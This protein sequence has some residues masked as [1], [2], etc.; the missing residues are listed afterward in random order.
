MANKVR[1][2]KT[3]RYDPVFLD[4]LDA[5]T[6]LQI[7][8]HVRVIELPGA[9]KANTMQHCHV[10]HLNGAFAG[11]VHTNSL[12]PQEKVVVG[13]SNSTGNKYSF[14]TIAEA[15]AFIATFVTKTD[16]DGV[17]AGNY[18]IDAP[19]PMLG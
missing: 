15:E 13:H 6:D 8:E 14:A 12:T 4:R 3:Y 1:V 18:Y 10:E 7:G 19:E 2:G 16:P 11:M 9:P 17:G 5:K